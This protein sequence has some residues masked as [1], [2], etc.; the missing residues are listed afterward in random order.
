MAC[1]LLLCVFSASTMAGSARYT[2]NDVAEE[3]YRQGWHLMNDG[4]YPEAVVK[5][6]EAVKLEETFVAANINLAMCLNN[7]GQHREAVARASSALKWN[8]TSS[9]AFVHRAKAY[10]GLGQYDKAVK[11]WTQAIANDPD[12][13]GY[14]ASRA[15]CW[16][17]LS[18]I[19]AAEKDRKKI[20]EMPVS[21]AYVKELQG[22]I[23]LDQKDFKSAIASFT[24]AYKEDPQ[25]L[26]ALHDRGLSYASLG[27]YTQ[28]IN[29]YN[30]CLKANPNFLH[31]YYMRGVAHI[32]TGDML[33]GSADLRTFLKASNWRAPHAIYAVAFC[34]LSDRRAG[35]QSAAAALLKDCQKRVSMNQW[36]AGV[37]RYFNGE[38]SADEVLKGANNNDLLTEAKAYIG[39][40]LATKGKVAEALQ[41]LQWVKQ[42][43]NKSFSEYQVSIAEL[44]RLL[45]MSSK[46]SL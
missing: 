30:A 31:C 39:F 11:D 22:R 34:V 16:M 42:N 28:A 7:L 40:D 15:R 5:Y 13:V 32:A 17:K 29:D 41:H 18:N 3:F 33:Q 20:L 36:P 23:F 6:R 44:K 45:A 27:N 4:K 1:T 19:A 37:I 25:A 12:S 26:D 2:N 24:A 43:G 21:N 35:N 8:P 46:K 10:E 14:Y 9:Y 38:I